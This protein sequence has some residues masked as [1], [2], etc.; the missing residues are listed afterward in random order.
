PR[1]DTGRLRPGAPAASGA[2]SSA[3]AAASSRAKPWH[4]R[5]RAPRDADPGGRAAPGRDVRRAR[6]AR[7]CAVPP[8]DVPRGRASATARAVAG[9]LPPDKRPPGATAM[10]FTLSSPGFAAG[11]SIP[12]QFTCDGNDIPPHLMWTGAPSGVVSYALIM[13][14]PDA[15]NGTFTHWVV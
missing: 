11:G 4:V 9:G 5:P 14:D 12:R 10:A 8:P 13:D 3:S 6:R 2:R 15:P 1:G 7:R